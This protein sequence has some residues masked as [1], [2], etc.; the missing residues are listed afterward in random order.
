MLDVPYRID[1]FEEEILLY[2][3]KEQFTPITTALFG[4]GNADKLPRSFRY[5]ALS[6]YH[7]DKTPIPLSKNLELRLGKAKIIIRPTTELT[8]YTQEQLL[9]FKETQKK[10]ARKEF[11]TLK[12]LLEDTQ[13][14]SLRRAD[15][16]EVPL[17]YSKA[18]NQTTFFIET[19]DHYKQ[20]IN[21][22]DSDARKDNF[23]QYPDYESQVRLVQTPQKIMFPSGDAY[24]K[25]GRFVLVRP[26]LFVHAA[27]THIINKLQDKY[28]LYED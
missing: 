20:L 4:L 23:T 18:K 6:S 7:P 21:V 25:K 12:Q 1:D 17:V 2:P 11:I 3:K 13:N 10:S 26:P 22:L 8:P 19:P 27:T 28:M 16:T 14:I 9:Q 24:V 5:D 15:K